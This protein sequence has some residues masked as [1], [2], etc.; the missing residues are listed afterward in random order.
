MKTFKL[1]RLADES[2]VSGTGI[3]AEGI[4]FSHGEAVLSW[5]TSHRSIGIYPNMKEL[6]NIHGHGGKTRVWWDGEPMPQR[7]DDDIPF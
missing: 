7:N 1:Y 6:E 2:G 4:E 3:V 5:L